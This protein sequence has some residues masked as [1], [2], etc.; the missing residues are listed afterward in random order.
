[1]SSIEKLPEVA[2]LPTPA[3]VTGGC[4][5]GAVRFRMD[6]PRGYEFTKNVSEFSPLDVQAK[7]WMHLLSFRSVNNCLADFYLP[8]HPVPSQLW[9]SLLVLRASSKNLPLVGC[10]GRGEH[11]C[12]PE[13]EVDG[14]RASALCATNVLGHPWDQ[15][16]ILR[17]LWRLSHMD[18]RRGLS[19]QC[20]RR[21]DRP[22]VPG[23]PQ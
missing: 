1:M 19:G 23:W 18:E 4:L 21:H 12:Q 5:C 22:G 11:N 20:V 16:N 3:R 2:P 17:N 9:L 10:G 6:F 7:L 15:S 8:V 14:F 13:R